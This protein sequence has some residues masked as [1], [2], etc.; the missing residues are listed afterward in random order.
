[1]VNHAPNGRRPRARWEW[2]PA[3]PSDVDSPVRTCDRA[4]AG[5]GDPRLLCLDAVEQVVIGVAEGAHSLAFQGRGYGT[6]VDSGA[7][8]PE[9]D[10]RGALRVDA[11][12]AAHG[13]VV[14]KCAQ[15]GLRH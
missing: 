3:C 11:E 7:V 15:G 2:V 13:A 6:D 14:G 12:R 1:M 10:L 8:G 9:E 4:S 5:G